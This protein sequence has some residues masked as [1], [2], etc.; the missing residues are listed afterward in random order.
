MKECLPVDRLTEREKGLLESIWIEF[1]DL[2]TKQMAE[3][4]VES[5]PYIRA[6]ER[7]KGVELHEKVYLDKKDIREDFVSLKN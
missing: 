1:Q 2:S 4:V 3:S 5:A 6:K 7:F